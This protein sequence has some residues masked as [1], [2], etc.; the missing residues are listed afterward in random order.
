MLALARY[1]L[2]GPYH[3]SAV[4]GI[5]AIV[6]VF[7]PLF[8][9]SPLLGAL[10]AMLLTYMS[11]SL[12]GLIILTQGIQSGIKAIIV[13]VLGITLVTTVVLE[14]P[15]LGISIA[16]AQWLPIIVLAQTYRTTSSIAVT[17]VA[18]VVLGIVAIVAQF[19]FLPEL[20]TGW[21]KIIMQ[22]VA[23][24]PQGQEY[25]ATELAENVRLMVHWLILA[26]GAS[27]YL[28]YASIVLVARW[29]QA[30]VANSDGYRREFLALSLGKPASILAMLLLALS[31]WLDFD[32]LTSL[33]ILVLAAF[34]FQGIAVVHAKIASSKIRPMVTGLFY[35]L[36]L[37]F[38]QIMA[39]TVLVGII[40]NWIIFRKRG[41]IENT[42]D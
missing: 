30:R 25:S 37:I 24:L 11:A 10:I 41:K 31:S 8:S 16:L 4:V 13:A 12:V 5:L 19:A 32:L 38:P 17:L 2:K 3:A 34:L 1:T 22:S 20:E 33:A 23:E 36:L 35:A 21:V 39:I 18:G 27:M 7:F 6:A 29:L 15:G 14:A 28:L 42:P 9:G 40:D 26:L